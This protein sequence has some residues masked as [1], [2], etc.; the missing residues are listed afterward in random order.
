MA[1]PLLKS[2]LEKSAML[3]PKV[4]LSEFDEGK[5]AIIFS[6][7]LTFRNPLGEPEIPAC[8]ETDRLDPIMLLHNSNNVVSFY[9][10]SEYRAEDLAVNLP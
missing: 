7:R 5:R 8:T 6:T 1:R 4:L 10:S 2:S 3:A 9:P